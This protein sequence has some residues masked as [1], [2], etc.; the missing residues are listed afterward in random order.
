M[1]LKF[2]LDFEHNLFDELSNT[3]KFDNI[4]KGRKG[5]ILVDIQNNLVPL[6]RSSTSYNLAPQKFTST[7]HH[8]IEQIKKINNELDLQFNNAMIEIYTSEYRT[9]GYHSDQS[10]DLHNDSYVCIFSCY[11]NSNN[12]S[13]LRK[14]I[15]K[16]KITQ[17]E[18]EIILEHNSCVL[19]SL[20]T[21]KKYLHRIILDNNTSD[22]SYLWLGITFR[23]SKTLINF[24]DGTPYFT[25]PGSLPRILRL[26]N[27]KEKMEFYKLRSNENKQIEFTYPEIDYTISK[28]DL[29]QIS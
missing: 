29:L 17:E 27:D 15:I 24:V 3:I 26:A 18:S 16:D 19:F 22:K 10:Q 12:S 8:V 7:H 2:N 9:M 20:S 23:L 25:N 21:N 11:N 4:T 6:V 14:L 28:S 5:A 1:F 13:D